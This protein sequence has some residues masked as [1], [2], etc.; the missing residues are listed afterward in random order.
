MNRHDGNRQ[1]HDA[2]GGHHRV[3][4]QIEMREGCTEKFDV[5]A[6]ADGGESSNE[7]GGNG[8]RHE[9]FEVAEEGE[10]AFHGVW[11]VRLL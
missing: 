1:K 5:E 11:K 8:S 3:V 9:E 6:N 2:H 4:A 10:E 7:N